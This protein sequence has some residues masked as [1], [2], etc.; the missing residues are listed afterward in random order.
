MPRRQEEHIGRLCEQGLPLGKTLVVHARGGDP[1]FGRSRIGRHCQRSSAAIGS[2]RSS[3]FGR[4]RHLATGQLWVQER[5]RNKHF[6]LRRV[7]GTENAADTLTKKVPTDLL[8]KHIATMGHTRSAGRAET[9][10]CCV[11]CLSVVCAC[12]RSMYIHIPIASPPTR[13]RLLVYQFSLCCFL[14]LVHCIVWFRTCW[15]S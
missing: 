4:V 2:C 12:V 10:P 5:L 9:V 3:G 1:I 6:A 11:E 7:L 8:D 15:Q 13:L 14:I